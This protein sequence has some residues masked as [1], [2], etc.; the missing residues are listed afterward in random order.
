[1][2]QGGDGSTVIMLPPGMT[3]QMFM[4]MLSAQR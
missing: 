2:Q 3:P 1:V 4:E